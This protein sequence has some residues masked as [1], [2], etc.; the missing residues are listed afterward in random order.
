MDVMHSYSTSDLT[1]YVMCMSELQMGLFDGLTKGLESMIGAEE[2][3]GP[4]I[5]PKVCVCAH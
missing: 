1:A 4:N 5:A 2:A 3:T